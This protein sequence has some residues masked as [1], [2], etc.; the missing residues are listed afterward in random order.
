SDLQ[1][2]Q[3]DAFLSYKLTCEQLINASDE[4]VLEVFI[5][6]NSYAVPVSAAELRNARYN[7]EFTDLVKATVRELAPVWAL[8]VISPRERVRMVDQ[9][10]VAE[11]F[12]F[13]MEGVREGDEARLNKLYEDLDK[14]EES[15]F[16]SQADVISVCLETAD[17]LG[18]FKGEA[19][20]A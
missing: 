17:L 2:D 13:F 8:G 16:P 6:I 19:I 12:A 3:K 4:D 9:S 14:R 18:G 20:V 7:N 10:V 5:R 15:S 11:I 1:D